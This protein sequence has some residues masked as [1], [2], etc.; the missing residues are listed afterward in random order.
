MTHKKKPHHHKLILGRG[1]LPATVLFLALFGC[2]TPEAAQAP[3][4]GVCQGSVPLI[5]D[6]EDADNQT[7]QAEG[8]GGYWYT[9]VDEAG[10]TVWPTAGA[11]GGT[12]EMSEGGADGTRSAMRFKGQ[13]GT[14]AVLFAGMGMNFVDPKGPYDTT[15]Y[16]GISFYAKK[17]SDS[18]GAVR[19]KMPD[20][21]TDPDGGKCTECFNDMGLDLHL[22][23]EWQK[24]D[25]PFKKLRQMPGWGRPRRMKIDQETMF[26]I[27]FQVNQPGASYDIWVDQI[28]FIGGCAQ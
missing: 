28:R 16:T 12:F 5:D 26:G 9:F 17:G 19:L 22:S 18:T 14:G 15:R 24:F 2:G 11:H 13:V 10:S 25:V 27:Q 21:F 20:A 1:P 7:V 23:E 6:A 3:Q 8:R 4:E